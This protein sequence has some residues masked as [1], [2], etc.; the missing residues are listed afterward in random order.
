[1]WKIITIIAVSIISAPNVMHI[2]STYIIGEHRADAIIKWE[3]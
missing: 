1:M 3:G 2:I